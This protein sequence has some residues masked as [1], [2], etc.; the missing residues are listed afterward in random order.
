[1]GL[2]HAISRSLSILLL[3][4]FV[5]HL[6]PSALYAQTDHAEKLILL[7]GQ[8]A[9][10]AH[11]FTSLNPA[12]GETGAFRSGY[13]T[14]LIYPPLISPDGSL[15]I[16]A[17]VGYDEMK[18]TDLAGNVIKTFNTPQQTAKPLSWSSQT[19]EILFSVF[20]TEGIT[21]LY[22]LNYF[23]GKFMRLTNDAAKNFFATWSPDAS[24]IAYMSDYQL[25]VMNS[26]GSDKRQ[27]ITQEARNLAWSPDGNYIAF[28]SSPSG[29]YRDFDIWLV[30]VDGR[31]LRNLSSTPN[32]VEA[33]PVWSPDSRQIAY[34][35]ATI[36][37]IGQVY[38]FTLDT[39]ET[40][41][42]T[43]KSASY[44]ITTWIAGDSML[45]T[46]PPDQTNHLLRKLAF[47]QDGNLYTVYEDGSGL[48][49]LTDQEKVEMEAIPYAWSDDGRQI[50]YLLDGDIYLVDL[51]TLAQQKISSGLD[52]LLIDWHDTLLAV[53]RHIPDPTSVDIQ[54]RLSYLNVTQPQQITDLSAKISI[55]PMGSG[56][57]ARLAWSSDGQWLAYSVGT[58][59]GVVNINDNSITD[60]IGFHPAWQQQQERLVNLGQTW[61]AT[62]DKPGIWLFDPITRQNHQLLE[63]PA[64]YVAYSPDDRYIA[65]ADPYL[66]RMTSV[67]GDQTLL[68][69]DRALAPAWS[70]TGD[71]LV[72]VRW[73]PG[74]GPWPVPDGIFIIN[75]DGTDRHQI[76]PG[77]TIDP[78]W[79]PQPAG[80]LITLSPHLLYQQKRYTLSYRATTEYKEQDVNKFLLQAAFTKDFLTKQGII[81]IAVYADGAK[82]TDV[83]VL[84]T[85][86]ELYLTAFAVHNPTLFSFDLTTVLADIDQ[87]ITAVTH[88]PVFMATQVSAL[89]TTRQ[90][91]IQA[92]L[93]NMLAPQYSDPQVA[94]YTRNVLEQLDD[95]YSVAE[96]VEKAAAFSELQEFQKLSKNIRETFNNWHKVDSGYSYS[97]L[98][99]SVANAQKVLTLAFN[100]YHLYPIADENLALYGRYQEIFQENSTAFDPDQRAAVNT[101]REEAESTR[102]QRFHIV[103]EFAFDEL[104][105][106]TIEQIPYQF[107]KWSSNR[108]GAFHVWP[109]WIGQAASGVGLGVSLGN[110]LMGIDTMYDHYKLAEQ[111]N[112]LYR[113]FQE[114]RH[115]TQASVENTGPTFHNGDLLYA[116]RIAY[117]LETQ[118]GIQTLR[119]YCDGVEATVQQGL[120]SVLNPISWLRGEEWRE[121]IADIR[122]NA[123]LTE[124]SLYESFINPHFISEIVSLSAAQTDLRPRI[125]QTTQQPS[126]ISSTQTPSIDQSEVVS[127]NNASN[128]SVLSQDDPV[129]PPVGYVTAEKLNVRAEPS[130]Q[131]AILQQLSE[132]AA[133]TIIEK[134]SNGQWLQIVLSNGKQGWVAAQYVRVTAAGADLATT[135]TPSPLRTCDLPTDQRV[136]HLWQQAQ[137]GCPT[138]RTTLTWA[139]W[140]PFEHGFMIWREDQKT[141]H[142]FT[143]RQT[144]QVWPDRW[145]GAPSTNVH[146]APPSGLQAPIR[147]FGAIWEKEETVFAALGWA[148][149][150]EKGFCLLVQPFEQGVLLKTI[151]DNSCANG[152]Y[153]HGQEPGFPFQSVK[154]LNAGTWNK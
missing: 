96:A 139:V 90:Q 105:D 143:D 44:S 31:R 54:L 88:N 104:K 127:G 118:A 66:K 11:K 147:G 126:V 69:E 64:Q 102:E 76:A 93:R 8:S 111:A 134:S 85:V 149:A 3:I 6:F 63:L 84:R 135:A 60:H 115:H 52:A 75:A 154:M 94:E 117:I 148:K 121:A 145:S 33:T 114:A 35:S 26:D 150:D 120:L 137:V 62:S 29:D 32:L 27:L 14:N 142:H 141:I 151:H 146:G 24:Q 136:Q 7:M 18:V 103:Q 56:A 70:P 153:N 68:T 100:L 87:E 4:S 59:G 108:F 9:E 130:T 57:D 86:V 30:A 12:N 89:L 22:K 25:W 15:M 19:Q 23:S 128:A 92:V 49:R 58:A 138:A 43:Q 61:I 17:G 71:A 132:G 129:Q 41:Q 125:V 45:A 55:L 140:Q 38:L 99:I 109:S 91:R 144:W 39:G 123:T 16:T 133:V 50:A 10:G 131:A 72:Y 36:S 106:Y 80:N 78:T 116:Y 107:V 97:G 95:S 77:L 40:R 65:Y 98:P 28:E 74:E 124:E 37:G 119:S 112:E 48:T 110:L 13:I 113:K 47:V 101:I 46:A 53:L 152:L 82:V 20:S 21:D 51:E 122:Q 67:G 5:F 83:S 73:V 42:L 81:E 79:Q 1:M 2:H 34:T